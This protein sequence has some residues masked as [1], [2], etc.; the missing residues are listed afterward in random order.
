MFELFDM[1]PGLQHLTLEVSYDETFQDIFDNEMDFEL[2][3]GVF[4]ENLGLAR[5][6]RIRSLKTLTLRFNIFMRARSRFW[7]ASDVRKNILMREIG[8]WLK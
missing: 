3:V 1:C 5:G 7:H 4:V 2:D 8:S 6:L